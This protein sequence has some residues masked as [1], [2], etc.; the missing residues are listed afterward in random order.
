M[1]HIKQ[2]F[3]SEAQQFDDLIAK[4]IPHYD[5]MVAALV[6]ALPFDAGA[7]IRV[8]DIG[9]GTGTI[10]FAILQTFPHAHITCLDLAEN[11]LAMARQKLARYPQ[12]HYVAD[13]FNHFEFAESYDAIVS[14]LALHH[15]VTDDDK[16]ALYRR[17]FAALSPG[18]VFYNADVILGANEF[19][20]SLYM[21][22]WRAFMGQ[23]MSEEEI[24]GT[25][26]P[27]Y[28]S[29]DRPASLMKQL[30][31]LAEIG[32]VEVDVIWKWYNYAVYGGIKHKV[33]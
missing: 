15:A 33:K 25:W 11:M 31:W 21:R 17:I 3:E 24:T 22:Q 4:L 8:F 19:L 6:A 7:P 30:S 27:K 23:H 26:L 10:S 13:D 14:S 16:R 12:V 20:Q 1:D 32:F 18:G 5:Q 28:E 9:C 29:E 2:H